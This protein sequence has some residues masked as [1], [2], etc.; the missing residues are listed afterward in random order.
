MAASKKVGLAV[1]GVVVAILLIAAIRVIPLI[2]AIVLIVA[3][4][5]LAVATIRRRRS[6][7]R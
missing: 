2:L 4:G 3:I 7:R 1:I 6:S 5:S